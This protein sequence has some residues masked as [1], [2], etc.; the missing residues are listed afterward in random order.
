MLRNIFVRLLGSFFF[1]FGSGAG[2]LD[3]L[4]VR[5]AKGGNDLSDCFVDCLRENVRDN[6]CCKP[7]A[8]FL[9]ISFA[10]FHLSRACAVSLTCFAAA[11]LDLA[12]LL[13]R[14]VRT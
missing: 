14:V 8:R 4:K 3:I 5:G 12:C 10:D 9:A 13:S 7:V 6:C 11:S 1:A 2:C